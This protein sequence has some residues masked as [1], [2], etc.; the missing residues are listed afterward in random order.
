M[1]CHETYKDLN[2]NWLS[3]EEVDTNNGK[4]FFKR[5][6]PNQKVNV[7]P[8]ESMSKSKKNTIDPE[9]IINSYG[10]DSV[11]LFIISDSPPEKDVQWSEQGMNASYKFIQKL[12]DLHLKVKSKINDKNNSDIDIEI[13]KFTHL[14]VDKINNNL[15]K[16]NYNVI[17]ANMYETYNFLIK[18]INMP[19][20]GEKLKENYIK[21]L[22][23]FSP[24]IPH[25]TS[26]CFE[27]INLKTFQEWPVIDK[28][29][30]E[31]TTIQ[32][33]IQI[34]GKK[35]GSIEVNKDISENEMID[36]VKSEN[37]FKKLFA[38]KN[39]NKIFFVKNRLINFLT[40]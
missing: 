15:D 8:S 35:R 7:G 31:K 9:K 11:R 25:F 6:N 19:L 26:E 5:E 21:I 13:T 18:K 3:P 30:L 36:K 38:G 14:L 40:S 22:S 23:S 10:A 39:I 34:N 29:L 2:G 24:I 28:K 12:W 32:F 16:F 17:V 1:V 20:N 27:D 37:S 33:V 4:E